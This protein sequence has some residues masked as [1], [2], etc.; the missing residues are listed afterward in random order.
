MNSKE[1]H[2]KTWKD[3]WEDIKTRKLETLQ[4]RDHMRQVDFICQFMDFSYFFD[5][6]AG[7]AYSEAWEVRKRRPKCSIVGFEPQPERYNLLKDNFYPGQ[8]YSWAVGSFCGEVNAAMGHK[9]GDS[10]FK[11]STDS[12][13]FESGAYL[14]TKIWSTTIDTMMEGQSPDLKSFVWADVEGAELEVLKGA[15]ES[16]KEQRMSGFLV[17]VITET[18]KNGVR[19]EELVSWSAQYGYHPVGMFN[20]QDTHFDCVFK[21]QDINESLMS[22]GMKGK[23]ILPHQITDVLEENKRRHQ[24]GD[25]TASVLSVLC[26]AYQEYQDDLTERIMRG[27]V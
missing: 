18:G 8:L 1:E 13:H 21:A 5:I 23:V 15:V 12:K 6:G 14:P 20:I 19:W 4:K 25:H 22:L 17:E 10:D 26:N 16:L 2:K 9:D 27:E 24:I 7:V 11:L 3:S